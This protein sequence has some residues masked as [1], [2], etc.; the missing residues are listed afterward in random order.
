MAV[1][2]GERAPSVSLM[3][4]G[5]FLAAITLFSLTNWIAAV[6]VIVVGAWLYQ[7]AR[8]RWPRRA[9]L[10]LIGFTVL[11]AAV[12]IGAG[13]HHGWAFAAGMALTPLYRLSRQR[14]ARMRDR[15][16]R[17]LDLVK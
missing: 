11:A 9:D 12:L 4:V 5:Y 17:T 10:A 3:F 7:F 8:G 15:D 13:D 6:A 1:V 2:L 14:R 16:D